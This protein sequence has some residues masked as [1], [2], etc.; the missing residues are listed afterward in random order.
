MDDPAPTP[1]AAVSLPNEDATCAFA[2]VLAGHLRP[3]DVI[4]LSGPLGIGKSVLARAV[5]RALDD[6]AGDVPSPTFTLVQLYEVRQ[7]PAAGTPVF[8]FD[9]YRLERPDDA[10][11]LGIEEAFADGISLVEWPE[12]LGPLLPETA[13]SAVL[14][15]GHGTDSRRIALQG[16]DRWTGLVAALNGWSADVSV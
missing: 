3:G 15:P 6:R 8:H 7:G 1:L 10:W 13:L 9:L 16:G 11:E 4:G 2:Q 12:R 14:S 5:V